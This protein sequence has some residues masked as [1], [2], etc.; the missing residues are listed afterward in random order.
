[1]LLVLS[2]VFLVAGILVA[3]KALA[4]N[5]AHAKAQEA[6]K[7]LTTESTSEVKLPEPE[8]VIAV[9]PVII[10]EPVKTPIVIEKTPTPTK[11]KKP[12]KKKPAVPKTTAKP[13]SSKK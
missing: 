9:E 6:T 8:P 3:R 11:T 13:L 7:L 12:A 5:K 4:D 1:M 2:I 10:E